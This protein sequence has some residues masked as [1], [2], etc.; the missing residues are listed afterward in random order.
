MDGNLGRPLPVTPTKPAMSVAVYITNVSGAESLICWSIEFARAAHVPLK[1]VIPRMSKGKTDWTELA[2]PDEDA[3][4]LHVAIF[5]TL[6][7]KYQDEIVVKANVA[8]S[9]ES[10]DH[11][12]IMVSVHAIQAPDPEAAFVEKLPDL[13]IKTLLLPAFMPAKNKDESQHSPSEQLFNLV[14]CQ[15][16]CIEGSPP[17]QPP[18]D[19]DGNAKPRRLLLLCE[20]EQDEDDDFALAKTAQ[21]ARSMSAEVTL[22]YVRPKDTAVAQEVADRHLNKIAKGFKSGKVEVRKMAAFADS[23]VDGANQLVLSQFDLIVVGTRNS[24]MTRRLMDQL[25]REDG[26]R[27]VAL[28]LTKCGTPLAE[29]VWDKL[30]LSIRSFVPQIDREHRAKL[31]DRLNSN[32]QFDFDFVALMSLATLIAA[33]GLARNSGA[34]VI[35]AML[36]APLMTPL[37]AIGLAL[38]QA[39][40]R[41]LKDGIKSVL[42]GFAVALLIGVVTGACIKLAAPGHEV[43]QQM[44]AR[45]APNMLDLIVALASGVAA[46]YAMGRPHLVSALPGVAIAAALVP[47]IATA[48]LA[49]PMGNLQLSGG[50][51]L[52]FFTNVIAIV[53]GTAVTFWAVGI[54]TYTGK[55]GQAVRT[56]PRYW[57]I[58]FVLVSLL[59]A[60]EMAYVSRLPGPV[61]I[62]EPSG[63][64]EQIADDLNK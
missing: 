40:Q 38:V 48:G 46:A 29:Q 61:Q 7:N 39:N 31:V 14:H 58:G 35:G 54:S 17:Q 24:K 20:G 8:D 30:K 44:L 49:I 10:T 28:A 34:V 15:V 6:S 4:A 45:N 47:P 25:Q 1:I 33:L 26:D 56:W 60:A 55:S 32:S 62:D 57:F 43:S 63:N 51:T 27:Q 19:D 64:V 11:D 9:E 37:V 59:L 13:D 18:T 12:R 21:L 41:L 2:K 52:L 53:L 16:I 42:L 3:G 22:L 23:F 50:A 36:V 5:E